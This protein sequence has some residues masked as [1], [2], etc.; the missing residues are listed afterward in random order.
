LLQ[1]FRTSG[2]STEGQGLLA[3]ADAKVMLLFGLAKFFA[4]FFIAALIFQCAALASTAGRVASQHL[5][6]APSGISDGQ[7]QHNDDDHV[8]PHPFTFHSSLF[9]FHFSLFT[10]HF[11]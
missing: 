4:V 7:D 9:T 8:L 5:P 2:G 1:L 6:Y 10:F 11:C 3:F